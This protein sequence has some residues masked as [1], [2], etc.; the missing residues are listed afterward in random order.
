MANY[1]Y[2]GLGGSNTNGDNFKVFNVG[3]WVIVHET[4]V[5]QLQTSNTSYVG[6]IVKT[7]EFTSKVHFVNCIN[8]ATEKIDFI[9][10]ISS[11]K[12]KLSIEQMSEGMELVIP[13]KDLEHYGP[14]E[15]SSKA[16]MRGLIHILQLQALDANDKEKFFQLGALI[17]EA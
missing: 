6:F 10:K 2:N 8:K 17:D 11:N 3:Q 9:G 15:E 1:R 13:N 5:Q 14:D 7:G 12:G 16:A 4:Q